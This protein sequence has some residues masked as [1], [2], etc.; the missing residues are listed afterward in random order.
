ML[1][2]Y[3]CSTNPILANVNNFLVIEIL[4]MRDEPPN[5]KLDRVSPNPINNR[6]NRPKNIPSFVT[7]CNLS[8]FAKTPHCTTNKN[9]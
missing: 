3:N 5:Y 6:S 9:F 4:K 1:L 7:V 2:T 8:H